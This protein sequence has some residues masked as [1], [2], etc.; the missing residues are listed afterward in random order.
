MNF[1]PAKLGFKMI[2]F[3]NTCKWAVAKTL[4]ICCIIITT[5]VYMNCVQLGIDMDL[6]LF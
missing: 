1:H 6:D 5:Q 2:Q 3:E 4:V